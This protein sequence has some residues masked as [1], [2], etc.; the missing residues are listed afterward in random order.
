MGLPEPRGQAVANEAI[1]GGI[2]SACLSA[3]S[4]TVE[5]AR[6]QPVPEGSDSTETP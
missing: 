6:G 5:C 1:A 2:R 3:Y 4:C